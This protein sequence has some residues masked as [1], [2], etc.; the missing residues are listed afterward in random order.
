MKI[1]LISDIH[2]N[3]RSLKAVLGEF[4]HL[5]VER[6]HCLGDMIG[7]LHQ[8]S[9]IIDEVRGSGIESIM[10]NHEATLLKI[11][12]CPPIRWKEYNMD[13]ISEHVTSDQI[14]WLSQ[15]VK[16]R[17]IETDGLRIA[18]YHGSP[19][20]PLEEYIYPDSKRFDEFPALG[21]DVIILGHTH[22]Q[23][24]KRI[25]KMMVLNP[26]SCGLPRDGIAG[27]SAAVF[28]TSVGDATFIRAEYDVAATIK[29][30]RLANASAKAIEKLS[31][32]CNS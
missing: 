14:S 1:G 11:I 26:G 10:G 29:E 15:L 32:G 27:A 18:L 22:R 2:G 24:L 3:L 31:K 23:M 7:Y 20:N 13:T 17:T 6:I 8:S 16:T 19:W 5:R 4:E 21:F 25:G 28:D 30:A 12:P 9:E